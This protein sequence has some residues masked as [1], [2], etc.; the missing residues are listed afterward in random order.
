MRLG[1]LN[2]EQPFSG[3]TMPIDIQD[4][5]QRVAEVIQNSRES[6]A[7]KYEPPKTR[8]SISTYKIADKTKPVKHTFSTLP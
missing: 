3:I 1:A 2:P 5:K 6:F 4:N 7:M 8:L